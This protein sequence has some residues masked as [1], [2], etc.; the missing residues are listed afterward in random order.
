MKTDN[1]TSSSDEA[2]HPGETLD[3]PVP[4]DAIPTPLDTRH[5]G[6]RLDQPV[7]ADVIPT[8]ASSSVAE[9]KTAT[10]WA[11]AKGMAHEFSEGKLGPRARPKQP[12]PVIHNA[13]FVHFHRA[14]ASNHWASNEELTEAEFDKAVAAADA[15]VYR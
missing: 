8:A 3:Q 9:K 2:R 5:P 6:E 1:K 4:A 15:H 13:K 11:K 14:R 7:P 12:K 10:E